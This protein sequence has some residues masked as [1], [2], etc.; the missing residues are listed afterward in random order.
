MYQYD[1]QGSLLW[2]GFLGG[3]LNLLHLL[4]CGP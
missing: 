3:S 4:S 1:Q 2:L